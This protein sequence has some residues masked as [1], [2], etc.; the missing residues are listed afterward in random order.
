MYALVTAMFPFPAPARNRTSKAIHSAEA[1]PNSI[2]KTV[3][4][5]NP[6]RRIGLRP[7]L[8]ESDPK[9]G[10]KR[11][12]PRV[13]AART[14]PTHLSLEPASRKPSASAKS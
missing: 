9:I 6:K 2:R 13:Y 4:A 8:S 11:N 10:V 12:C 14:I 7:I 1:N 3:F 5:T